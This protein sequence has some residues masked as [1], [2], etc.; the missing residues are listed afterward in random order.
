MVCH[1]T[2]F[3]RFMRYPFVDTTCVCAL[4]V[5]NFCFSA[6]IIHMFIFHYHPNN[7]PFDAYNPIPLA[8]I[9]PSNYAKNVHVRKKK[10]IVSL[11]LRTR[12]NEN[13]NHGDTLA[14][15]KLSIKILFHNICIQTHHHHQ[16]IWWLVTIHRNSLP[17]IGFADFCYAL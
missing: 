16:S 3:S 9:P 13:H 8:N 7:T 1:K 6:I 10:K 12:S 5:N 2:T 14:D 15:L 4:G 11:Q 17:L